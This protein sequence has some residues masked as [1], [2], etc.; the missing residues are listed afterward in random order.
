MT[1]FSTLI[2]L[3]LIVAFILRVDFVFYIIYVF[4]GVYA[5]SRWA[6]P[7]AFKNLFSGRVYN[8]HAFW[9]ESVPITI[10]LEN[11]GRLPLSWV[12]ISESVAVQLKYSKPVNEV[13]SLGRQ[14]ACAFTYHISARRRGY[15]QIGPMR[16][17]TG[18]MFGIRPE[19]HAVLPAEYITI[20]PRIIRLTKLGLPS[21]LPFGNIG[22]HQ[23]LFEDPARPLGV[24]DFR[25]GDSIR[26]I[27]WKASAHTRQLV[28]KTFAPAIS[29]ETAVLLDLHADAYQRNLRHT[30][31]E[32]AIEVAASLAAHLVDRRQAVG[33]MTNGIDPLSVGDGP[34]FDENSGRLLRHTSAAVHKN[35][36]HYL[37]PD[38]PPRNGRHHLIK[39]LERLA[40]IE[41]DSTLPFTQWAADATARLSWGV[42]TLAIVPRGSEAVCQVCHRLVRAGYN[43]VLITVE[44]DA[45]FSQVRNRARR[46]GF[47]AYN[48]TGVSDLDQWR[49]APQGVQ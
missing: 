42:T 45:N 6:T 22:S 46:L 9:G 40:R 41:S 10:K 27:N 8:H 12:R 26:Q 14:Q 16:L 19:V 13:F 29:L 25:S 44:P 5:W 38:I 43:P 47:V 1:Q 35:P 28:V 49:K 18:D 30:T 37:P 23:R 11:K 2:V 32:W 31:V 34:T 33:L 39:I 21:R 17:T 3:M 48:V 7:R 15:Y 24:R 20:Y 36:K 4:I